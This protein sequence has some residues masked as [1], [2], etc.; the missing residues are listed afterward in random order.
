MLKNNKI[1]YVAPPFEEVQHE[2]LVKDKDGNPK[3]VSL[4]SDLSLMMRIENMRVDARTF[5]TIQQQLQPLI[6]KSSFK[7]EIEDA[8]GSLTDDEMI[9]SCPSRYLSTASEKKAYLETLAEEDK[10]VK[11][12]AA[13]AKADKEAEDKRTKEDEEFSAALREYLSNF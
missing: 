11:A 9:D 8:F 4:H 13:K 3:Q 10:E 1:V 2:V 12:K 5:E 7:E 6:D